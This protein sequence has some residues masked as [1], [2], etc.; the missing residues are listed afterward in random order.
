[1]RDRERPKSLRVRAWEI[2]L[3]LTGIVGPVAVATMGIEAW[4]NLV[5]IKLLVGLIGA[6]FVLGIITYCLMPKVGAAN[7]LDRHANRDT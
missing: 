1:M 3:T 2:S 7:G 4:T 5:P 6:A